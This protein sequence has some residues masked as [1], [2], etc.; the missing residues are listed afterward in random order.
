MDMTSN[1][2]GASTGTGASTACHDRWPGT[3]AKTGTPA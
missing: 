2:D 3:A 1:G